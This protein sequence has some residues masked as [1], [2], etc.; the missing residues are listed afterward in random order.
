MVSFRNTIFFFKRV[1]LFADENWAIHFK[2]KDN[3]WNYLALPN[4][5]I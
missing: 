4:L 5:N 1:V 2:K 3:E